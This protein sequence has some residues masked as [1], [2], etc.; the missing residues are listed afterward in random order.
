MPQEEQE[1]KNTSGLCEVTEN[2]QRYQTVVC[3]RN[4]IP[5]YVCILKCFYPSKHLEIEYYIAIFTSLR[6]KVCVESYIIWIIQ[7]RQVLFIIRKKKKSTPLWELAALMLMQERWRLSNTTSVQY[8]AFIHQILNLTARLAFGS[9]TT[10]PFT[11]SFY[12]RTSSSETWRKDEICMTAGIIM[13]M[14]VRTTYNTARNTLTSV[15]LLWNKIKSLAG[16]CTFLAVCI[17][18]NILRYVFFLF[19]FIIIITINTLQHPI[20]TRQPCYHHNH[21]HYHSYCSSQNLSQQNIS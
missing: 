21:Y 20:S 7:Q 9:E 11:H 12:S 2:K 8:S 19:F 14:S 1:L 17:L 13:M 6:K 4:V 18:G 3:L 5:I 10:N 16:F 15:K